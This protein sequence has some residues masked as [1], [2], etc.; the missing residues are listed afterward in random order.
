MLAYTPPTIEQRFVLD[1]V[2]RIDELAGHNAFSDATADL[3]DAIVE[4]AG[5]FAL[6]EYAPLNRIGDMVGAVWND[7]TVTM[8]AGF[9][10]A[11]RALVDNGWGTIVG[12]KDAGGQGLPFTLGTI[13]LEDLGT[14][15]M[16][17]TLCNMLTAGAVEALAVHGS[18][19]LQTTYLPKLVSGEWTGTMNL[20]EPQ[21]GSDVGALRSTAKPVGD[22]SWLIAGTKIFITFGEHD[23]TENIVHL[24]LA[25]TPDAPPGTKGIS[26]FLVPKLRPDAQGAFTEPNDVRCVSIEHKLGI[27]ASPTCVLSFGDNGDCRG[28]LVGPELGGMRAMFTMM[29]NAR[30]NVGLQGIQIGERATQ[31]AISYARD[32]IQGQPII[33]HPDVRRMLLRMK[34]LTQAARSLVYA[35][36]GEVDRA[37]LGVEG[38]KARV[39]LLTPLAKAYGTDAG[40]EI[41]SL[42]VQVHGGM[43]FIEETGAAQHY[44]DIRIAPIYE[45]TNGIQAADLVGRKLTGDGGAALKALIDEVRAEA[46][47]EVHLMALVDAVAVAT[48]WLLTTEV[49]DRLA[50]SYPFLDMVSVMTCG[51]LMARQGRVA[52]EMLKSGS[53]DP[54]FLK[55]KTVT[56]RYYLDYLVPEAL[57]KAAA[58]T[59]GSS[60]LYELTIEELAA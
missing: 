19:E 4:G 20:T 31:E 29:N 42:G 60:L 44:R 26:L 6:A 2:V 15:N 12:P 54:A 11:Y 13:V 47:G 5:A 50:G 28:W 55:A 56:T 3:V 21:A 1:H 48:D 45:G 24:V 39:D 41:A 7:G 22:G 9:R 18:E 43:G 58:A 52:A 14:A 51:W 35:A 36:A 16:A 38:A 40:C 57:G 46:A 23:L 27:H 53:G 17:F 37:H 49:N 25:R 32:R 30:L 34:S 33:E 8:P 59:A 10:E